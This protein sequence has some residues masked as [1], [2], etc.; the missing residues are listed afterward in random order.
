MPVVARTACCALSCG[1]CRRW[2]RRQAAW[3]PDKVLHLVARLCRD[4]LQAAVRIPRVDRLAVWHLALQDSNSA[5]MKCDDLHHVTATRGAGSTSVQ[6]C[7]RGQRLQLSGRAS[8]PHLDAFAG[9]VCA[10]RPRALQAA[11]RVYR[12]TAHAAAG[13]ALAAASLVRHKAVAALVALRRPLWA[14]GAGGAG[15]G[16]A[17]AADGAVARGT[18][19]ALGAVGAAGL[20]PHA[21]LATLHQRVEKGNDVCFEGVGV[22]ETS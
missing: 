11:A 7:K 19:L 1:W 5:P 16:L 3:R 21:V 4:S 6:V 20:A 17:A 8:E 10:Q 22:F 15:A 18:P 9:R 2:L 14:A 12:V 13:G